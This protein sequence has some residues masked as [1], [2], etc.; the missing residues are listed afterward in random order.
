MYTRF[1]HPWLGQTY[2]F[3]GV[4]FYSLRCDL[5]VV[6]YTSYH[7]N[8]VIGIDGT[9]YSPDANYINTVFLTSVKSSGS[10]KSKL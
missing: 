3:R 4:P 7:E 10:C 1:T 5:I 2:K 6:Y 9:V 8:N